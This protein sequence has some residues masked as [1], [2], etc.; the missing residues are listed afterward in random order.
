MRSFSS[1]STRDSHVVVSAGSFC[2]NSL[3]LI[4]L[5]NMARR[6]AMAFFPLLWRSFLSHKRLLQDAISF[7]MLL[8]WVSATQLPFWPWSCFI[9]PRC[10]QHTILLTKNNTKLRYAMLVSITKWAKQNLPVK[11]KASSFRILVI[12]WSLSVCSMQHFPSIKNTHA[13]MGEIDSYAAA[14][15]VKPFWEK[16]DLF[17]VQLIAQCYDLANK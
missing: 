17:I 12:W 15:L 4:T 13:A 9:K 1:W 6:L 10:L 5:S 8:T 14:I 2:D 7:R 11:H 16:Q 3:S